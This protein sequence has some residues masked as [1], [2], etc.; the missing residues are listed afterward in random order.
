M[1]YRL[2]QNW[3]LTGFKLQPKESY[4]DFITLHSDR[5][6]SLLVVIYGGPIIDN[7]YRTSNEIFKE[8]EAFEEVLDYLVS[9]SR[10]DPILTASFSRD[11]ERLRAFWLGVLVADS[12]P[13]FEEVLGNNL[14]K[15]C[16]ES[17]AIA[18][19]LSTVYFSIYYDSIA[20]KPDYRASLCP[21]NDAITDFIEARIFFTGDI[22]RPINFLWDCGVNLGKKYK[23]QDAFVNATTEDG[24]YLPEGFNEAVTQLINTTTDFVAKTEFQKILTIGAKGR[25]VSVLKKATWHDR[26]DDVKRSAAQKR[27]PREPDILTSNLTISHERSL[28]DDEVLARKK[29]FADEDTSFAQNEYRIMLHKMAEFN[30][31]TDRERQV[32]VL[33]IAGSKEGKIPTNKKVA[34]S[35]GISEVR[36]KQLFDGARQ[37]LRRHFF[38]MNS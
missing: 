22:L 8:N 19:Y 15:A 32:L 29:S 37:K 31:L 18:F 30:L 12:A 36:V 21:E 7:L 27:R 38:S 2:L 35:M 14:K 33:K 1:F 17:K 23:W 34:E 3:E 11:R 10:N 13:D 5:L 26:R 25:L 4:G 28:S 24:L 9:A 16:I 20:S 6:A